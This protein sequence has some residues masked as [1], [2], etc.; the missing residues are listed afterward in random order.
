MQE[1]KRFEE[2]AAA[3]KEREQLETRVQEVL[4]NQR[5]MQEAAVRWDAD[6]RATNLTGASHE[7]YIVSHR[8]RG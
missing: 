3:R 2:E 6:K 7:G 8:T 1:Y 4:F 5:V